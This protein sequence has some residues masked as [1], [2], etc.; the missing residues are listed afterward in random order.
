MN[1][2]E[3]IRRKREGLA[4]DPAELESLVRAYVAGEVEDYQVSALL[5]AIFFRGMTP[6]EAAAL[7]RAMRDSGR[8]HDLSS[9]PGPKIDKHSTGGVGDKVSL[10]LA[11]LVAAAGIVDPMV[12]GRGLG[13][14]GGTLDKLDSIP[15]YRWDIAEDAFKKQLAEVG[16][17]IIGQTADF[18]PA[19]KKLYALRDVTATVE[20]IPLI[21]ASILS[22]K[23]ASGAE[24]LVMDVKC[25]SGAFMQ[26]PGDARALA[27]SLVSIGNE[28]GLRTVAVVTQMGQPLGTTVGNAL[29]VRETVELLHGKGPR[30][31]RD[32]T[33]ELGAEMLVLGEIDKTVD[34]ARA[35]L[36]K[37]L[38]GGQALEKFRQWI[39]AQGGDARVAD[40]L[41]LL[42]QAPSQEDFAAP[43][44]GFVSAMD[45]RAIGVAGNLLGAG[46]QCTTDVVDP[47]VGFEV[48]KK[49]GDRVEKGEPMLR[50]HHAKGRGLDECKALLS[51]AITIGDE[52]VAALPLVLERTA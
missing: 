19:D 26:T 22:K 29:E 14:S 42:P 41:S 9:I 17:A 37:L 21:C 10:V 38:D 2:P 11:P 8:R 35:R 32:V 47:A 13:H 15:G 40:D 7:T 50:I 36:V 20:S 30:D 25:G 16:C 34:A 12:S 46:R 4:L 49:V 1:V 39:A 31:T 6:A 52:K 5:M 45:T 28:L 27:Q 24:G 3:L 51:D 18:V 23:C 33:L 48:M 44:A 43:R